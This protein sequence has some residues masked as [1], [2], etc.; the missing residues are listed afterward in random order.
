MTPTQNYS[1]RGDILARNRFLTFLL[2]DLHKAALKVV[3]YKKKIQEVIQDKHKGH[4]KKISYNIPIWILRP[5]MGSNSLRPTFF[6]PKGRVKL[7]N[8]ERELLIPQTKVLTLPFKVCHGRDEKV[9]NQ[10]TW[11]SQR[12]FAWPQQLLRLFGLFKA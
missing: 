2:T 10:N 8:L 11:C 12:P 9:P 1:T 7:K 6:F 5:L 3:N 4:L